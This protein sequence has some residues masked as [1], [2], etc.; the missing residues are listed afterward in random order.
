MPPP[1]NQGPPI[2]DDDGTGAEGSWDSGAKTVAVD[3]GVAG[4]GAAVP[5][6]V[7]SKRSSNGAKAPA[8]VELGC[9]DKTS[10]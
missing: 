5:A 2:A 7:T 6:T 1:M 10:S 8:A 9:P 4:G 3:V